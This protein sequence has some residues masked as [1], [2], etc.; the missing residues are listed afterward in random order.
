LVTY[1]Q[2]PNDAVEFFKFE[3]KFG[4]VYV[5]PPSIFLRRGGFKLGETLQFKDHSGKE[6]V[7]EIGP[8]EKDE[9]GE[10]KV[11]L[12][13]DHHEREYS[14]KE[15]VQGSVAQ[16]AQL[17]KEEVEDLAKAGDV[18][19]PFKANVCEVSV[20]EGQEVKVGDRLAMVEAMKMQT[21][22]D[23]AVN[24]KVEKIFAELGQALKVGD[25]MLKIKVDEG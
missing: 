12:N 22:V 3:E 10:W 23:S 8:K 6:H 5:L 11:Y 18:R 9:D 25:K 1:L 21:P 17:T 19:A 16:E 15:V 13:V 2:D 14:F 24:G 20:E 4:K 7:I